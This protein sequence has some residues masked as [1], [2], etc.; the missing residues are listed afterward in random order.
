[1]RTRPERLKASVC[2][3]ICARLLAFPSPLFC[4]ET[5]PSL[6]GWGRQ[7]RAESGTVACQPAK[8]LYFFFD[9]TGPSESV[10]GKE[11]Y[12]N[13]YSNDPAADTPATQVDYGGLTQHSL[14]LA[15]ARRCAVLCCGY[16]L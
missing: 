15:A 16:L 12:S 14:L 9:I 6:S 7:Y 8:W 13:C 4:H 10:R 2:R 5:T 1:M 11:L 3:A